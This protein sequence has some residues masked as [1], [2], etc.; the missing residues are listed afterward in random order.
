M[1]NKLISNISLQSY[2]VFKELILKN[3]KS[4]LILILMLLIQILILSL[5]IVSIVPLA[6]YLV[7]EKMSNPNKITHFVLKF[8]EFFNIAKSLTFFL[9]FFFL[10]AIFRSFSEIIITRQIYLIRYNLEKSLFSDFTKKIFDSNWNFFFKYTSGSLFNTYTYI[11]NQICA[12]F[13]AIA[14]QISLFIKLI[15]YLVIPTLINYKITLF[16]VFLALLALLPLKFF[17]KMS[18]D[19]G[20]KNLRAND[21]FL[22]NLSETFQSI[23]LIFGFNKSEDTF[24]KNQTSFND[25]IRYGLKTTYLKLFV[26]NSFYPIG[27]GVAAITFAIF[28]DRA[29]DLSILAAVFWSLVSAVPVLQSLVQ[30]NLEVANLSANYEQYKKTTKDSDQ[31]KFINGKIKFLSLENSIR[32]KDVLFSYDN[33]K[34]I[35]NGVNF[36]IKKNRTYLISG[37]SGSGKSTLIDL[38]M[39][40]QKPSKGEVIIDGNCLSDLDIFSYRSKI[41]YVPQEPFLYDGTI[42]ENIIW[43]NPDIKKDDLE[44]ILRISNC[45]DFINSLKDQINTKVGER[46]NM[47]SGGQKQRIALARALAKKP[48][49]LI[50]D[51]ATNSLDKESS[52]LI[53]NSLSELNEKCTIIIIS[54]EY[55]FFKN[56]KEIL[57]MENGK[58]KME[59]SEKSG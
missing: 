25:V 7:D 16:A 27:L 45:K 48:E 55:D 20:T 2:V 30:G 37:A 10:L 31:M 46:G 54:H 49:I 23:K 41:G 19:L 36:E 53:K 38:I 47:L 51:E 1:I 34:N 59:V 13:T 32:F 9:L 8:L 29:T 5:S 6:D 24:K 58:V 21:T 22:K 15:A 42:Y 33:N 3:K 26:T 39:G 35:I 4:F 43:A 44:N 17:T 40:F 57:Y 56:V 11:I 28:M 18:H 52:T 14:V 12:G 50:L